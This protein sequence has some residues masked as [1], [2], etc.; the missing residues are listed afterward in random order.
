MVAM[1]DLVA[2]FQIILFPCMLVHGFAI[3][4]SGSYIVVLIYRRKFTRL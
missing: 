1:L 2:C 3:A 4:P